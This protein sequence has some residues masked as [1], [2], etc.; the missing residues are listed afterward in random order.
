MAYGDNF[1][2]YGP[3]KRKDSRQ[4]VVVIENNGGPPRTVSYPKWLMEL[5]LGR[6][7]DPN[8]ET[9]DH[10]DSDFNNND[11]SNLRLVPRNEHSADDTRRVKKVKFTCAWCNK[12]FERSPRLIRDKAKKNKAGPFCSRNCAGKYSRMLQLKLID[13][14]DSQKAVDSEYYKR[15]YV[16]ASSPMFTNDQIVD[17][18][19][20]IWEE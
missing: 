3:Y 15:K 2:V 20:D 9:V 7:L 19:C 14:F 5:Q 12:E 8:L 13:K 16:V 17:Y 10:I 4:T 18:L 1:K 11:Y 6:R